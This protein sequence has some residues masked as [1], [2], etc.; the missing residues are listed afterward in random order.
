MAAAPPQSRL[1]DQSGARSLSELPF[2]GRQ[3]R[4]ESRPLEPE[5][6]VGASDNSRK[7]FEKKTIASAECPGLPDPRHSCRHRHAAEEV[8]APPPPPT[9]APLGAAGGLGKE[10]MRWTV[11]FCQMQHAYSFFFGRA[12]ARRI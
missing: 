6:S 9:P 10:E 8:R 2:V 12:S 11:T 4:G 3:G 5:R 7:C 1:G